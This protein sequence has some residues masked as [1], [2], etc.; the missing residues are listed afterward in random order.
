METLERALRIAFVVLILFLLVLISLP[1]MPQ[2]ID[3]YQHKIAPVFG[4][5]TPRPVCFEGAPDGG[6]CIDTQLNGSSVPPTAIVP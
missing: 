5:P 6:Y 3:Y 2:W 4:V 1:N